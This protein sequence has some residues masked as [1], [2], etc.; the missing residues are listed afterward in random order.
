L[1]IEFM[2]RLHDR[3]NVIPVIAKADTLTKDELARFKK[4]VLFAFHLS[5]SF[6][7]SAFPLQIVA[8]M[9]TNQIKEYNF[10]EL[11]DVDERSVQ[12]ALR[13]RVPF[14]VVGSNAMRED[15]GGRRT[16]YREYAWGTVEVE[17]MAHNDFI[18]LRD[19]IIG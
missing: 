13:E 16:R 15:A 7:H 8:D 4:Q 10:P 11:D 2:K 9:K 18:A 12:Q 1:D 3:V 14:A 5:L 6:V 17:N 19:M